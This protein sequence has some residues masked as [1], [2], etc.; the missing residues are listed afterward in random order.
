MSWS[1]KICDF[2]CIGPF[3]RWLKSTWWWCYCCCWCWWWANSGFV[4][5]S[6]FTTGSFYSTSLAHIQPISGCSLIFWSS[7]QMGWT[8]KP[9]PTCLVGHSHWV[10]HSSH[11]CRLECMGFI[12]KKLPMIKR[13][14]CLHFICISIYTYSQQVNK[15][16]SDAT[17]VP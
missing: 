8:R 12:G 14:S 6:L 4:L 1:S 10:C 13:A 17:C 2:C 5:S 9:N 11:L 3:L 16:T 7:Y 15:C